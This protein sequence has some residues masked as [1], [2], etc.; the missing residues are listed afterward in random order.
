METN[1]KCEKCGYINKSEPESQCSN[2]GEYLYQF[3]IKNL[4]KAKHKKIAIIASIISGMIIVLFLL[5]VSFPKNELS[6]TGP[7]KQD[8]TD[9]IK[10]DLIG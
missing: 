8:L 7:L 3:Y 10:K 5:I 1:I 9:P 2:C 4:N 6:I